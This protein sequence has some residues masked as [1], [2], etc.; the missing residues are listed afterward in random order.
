M[1]IN[2]AHINTQEIF[3]DTQQDDETGRT[4]I[5]VPPLPSKFGAIVK[6][7]GKETKKTYAIC[8]IDDRELERAM[9]DATKSE[10][11]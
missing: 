8:K 2:G 1:H 11:R 6:A 5:T 10:I 7:G 9:S 3:F 4:L